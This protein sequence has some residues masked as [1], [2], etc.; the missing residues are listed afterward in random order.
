MTID[1]NAEI[2]PGDMFLANGLVYECKNIT[3]MG[4]IRSEAGW[5][6]PD[7]CSKI[8]SLT[9]GELKERLNWRRRLD[10][11]VSRVAHGVRASLDARFLTYL[12]VFGRTV[13]RFLDDPRQTPVGSWNYEMTLENERRIREAKELNRKI[14]NLLDKVRKFN[15]LNASRKLDETPP[16]PL[17]GGG[18]E[19]RGG[20]KKTE[21]GGA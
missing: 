11:T 9:C 12:K 1:D 15:E 18:S 21:R 8:T 5:F 20:G 19:G 17:A 4:I 7:K 13:V 16:Y 6:R 3:W 14:V 10:K 2:K